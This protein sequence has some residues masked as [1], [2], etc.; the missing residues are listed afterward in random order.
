MQVYG[1]HLY[2]FPRQVPK[3]VRHCL[4][5][6][7]TFHYCLW[8]LCT[9]L[10]SVCCCQVANSVSIRRISH[11]LLFIQKSP[12]GLFFL[13]SASICANPTTSIANTFTIQRTALLVSVAA[14]NVTFAMKKVFNFNTQYISLYNNNN[15][16][17]NGLHLYSAFH[18]ALM[19]ESQ[20][21]HLQFT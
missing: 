11:W 17:N 19:R 1:H 21:S 20:I 9:S 7:F 10:L 6:G 8:K 13:L 12:L 5:L 4:S 15:N 3:D 14:F 2:E 18:K 16:N